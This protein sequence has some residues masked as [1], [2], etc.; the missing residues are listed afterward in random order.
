MVMPRRGPQSLPAVFWTITQQAGFSLV[1]MIMVLLLLG[2]MGA[3]AGLGI[4]T[5]VNVFLVS[6]DAAATAAKGQLALLRLSR[7]F[8][9]ITAV[10][11]ASATS[12]QFAALHGDGVTQSYTVAKSGD[13]I[14]LNDGVGN[15][16]LVDQVNSLTF[17]YYD[18]YG[19]AA[20]TTWTSA[21]KIIQ[22]TIALNGPDSNILSFSTRITPR[23]I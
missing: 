16:I 22:A 3:G 20:Q 4:S 2:V 19:G 14:I 6:R 10:T 18:T 8:R 9:V 12:I 1:E 15:D 13:T 23:N 21:R 5:V 7:E 11:S 17:A